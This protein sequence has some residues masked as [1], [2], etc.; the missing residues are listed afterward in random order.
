[1]GSL[2]HRGWVDVALVVVNGLASAATAL[3]MSR[4]ARHLGGAWWLG[5]L[6]LLLPGSFVVL[7]WSTSE[8]LALAFI[9]GA[10]WVW[11]TIPEAVVL[12]AALMALAVLTRET[13]VL[14]PAGLAFSV[15]INGRYRLERDRL[16]ALVS[17]PV[18]W[19]LWVVSVRVRIGAW[20]FS[21]RS[22]RL[23]APFAGLVGAL[24]H[25]NA[26]SWLDAGVLV[27]LVAAG[28]RR[29]RGDLQW[30]VIFQLVLAALM[31]KLVWGRAEDFTRVLLPL[32]ALCM[33]GLRTGAKSHHDEAVLSDVAKG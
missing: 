30:V 32:Y 19:L 6:T 17:T 16:L 29:Y 33:V 31:G 11:L 7:N 4:L 13:S 18:P 27:V 3:A 8:V 26:G 24:P 23:G 25:W 10:L 1:M 12:P 20:S 5:P 2:G 9:G 22:G 14:V 28:L 21:S 15:L